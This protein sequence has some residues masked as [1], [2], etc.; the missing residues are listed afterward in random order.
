MITIKLGSKGEEVK[1]LQEK[2]NCVVDGI[3]GIITEEAVK[4]F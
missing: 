2:L 4:E 1:T 3:F